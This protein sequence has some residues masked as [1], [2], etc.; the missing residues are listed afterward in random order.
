[1]RPV[2]ALILSNALVSAA[3]LEQWHWRSPLPQGNSLRSVAYGNGLYVAVGDLGTILTSPDGTNWVRQTSGTTSG[4]RD[5]AYDGG[6]WIAVGDLGTVLTSPDARV[7]TSQYPGTFFSLNAVTYGN[8]Q[9]VAVGEATTILT[10]SD[11]V[12]W[13]SRSSGALDLFDVIYED[14]VY[15]AVGGNRGSANTLAAGIIISSA[16]ATS[17]TR[18]ETLPDAAVLSVTYGA[19]TFVAA[20]QNSYRLTPALWVS[21]DGYSWEPRGVNVNHWPDARVAYGNGVWVLAGSGFDSI[22]FDTGAIAISTNLQS[23]SQVVSNT[24]A[25][26]AI[27][28]S[29]GKF[30]MSRTDGTV[31]ISSDGRT[32]I[33]PHGEYSR[34]A[35]YD[36]EYVNGGWL[37]LAYDRL[38]GSA[39]GAAWTNIVVFTNNFDALACGNG[40]CVVAS[41]WQVWRSSN[42]VDWTNVTAGLGESFAPGIAN[43]TFGGGLFVAVSSIDGTAFTS[44]DGLEWSRWQVTAPETD[45]HLQGIAYGGGRFVA[46]GPEALATSP[47]GTNWHAV[48]TNFIH[49]STVTWGNGRFVAVGPYGSMTTTDGTNWLSQSVTQFRVSDVAFGGGFFV[50]IG[51][52]DP[53]ASVEAPVWVSTDGLNW[54]RRHLHVARFLYTVTFGNGTFLVTGMSGI[55]LQSDPVVNLTVQIGPEPQLTLSGS[56]GRSYRI[57]HADG[58][59]AAW[60][61]L[62]TVFLDTGSMT[63]NDGE[64]APTRFYRA[65]LL[66]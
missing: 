7:W 66:P 29:Q 31:L 62:R 6:I 18:R 11:A 53:Y 30:V 1:M 26:S 49:M 51:N 37:G 12:S 2:A 45:M 40:A 17:W 23:W 57:D 16:D 8:G 54:S 36:V 5:C 39:D 59:H 4:L 58:P 3:P 9:F 33:N 41:Y 19:G 44:S 32:W 64:A 27:V 13:T 38:L 50:A 25:A 46:V 61:P 24:A 20:A 34:D 55:V 15:V 65:V 47:D 48:Q 21:D 35:L 63:L 42:L 52:H 56:A 14:G 10:S 60:R 22:Y 43:V 28:Y